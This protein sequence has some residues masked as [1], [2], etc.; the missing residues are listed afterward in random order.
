MRGIYH[1]L[2]V[3]IFSSVIFSCGSGGGSGT[4]AAESG[5]NG[6]GTTSPWTWVAGSKTAF[7]DGVVSSNYGVKGVTAPSNIPGARDAAITWVDVNDNLWLFGGGARRSS[8]GFIAFNDLWRFD[9]TNW[10]WVSGSNIEN[11]IGSYGVQ[12]VSGTTNVPGARK[13]SVSW[14]DASGNLWLFGGY[15]SAGFFND[16]W[17]FDGSNWTWVSGSNIPNQ[18]DNYGVKGVA[19]SANIPGARQRSV[20]WIDAS[21]NLWLFG[22]SSSVG[23]FNDLWKFDGSNWT[24]V[25]GS[26]SRGQHGNYGIK[27]VADADNVPGARQSSVSW[28]D[29]SG[30]LWLFGGQGYTFYG[31]PL[32][33]LWKFDGSNWTWVAGNSDTVEYATIYGT[34]NVGDVVNTPGGRFCSMNW[35]DTSGNL[36]LFGGVGNDINRNIGL[37]NDLWKFDGLNWIWVAGSKFMDQ[38]GN[39][40]PE[41]SLPGARSCAM[42]WSDSAGNLWLYGGYGYDDAGVLGRTTDLWRYNP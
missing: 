18:P 1:L 8:G 23:S 31:G 17:K 29:T 9:G 36:W 12:G 40:E 2:L 26:D 35:T 25:S 34:Q 42:N 19:N 27:G 13:S 4:E 7:P 33:D 15:S 21:D 39:Y 16:L 20:S 37:L 30:N 3:C 11:Q 28:V 10:T 24:W 14:I 32:N 5:G 22:G 41:S 38:F 6:S